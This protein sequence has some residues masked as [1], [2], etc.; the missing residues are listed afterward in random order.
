MKEVLLNRSGHTKYKL[1]DLEQLVIP[2]E[3]DPESNHK[4]KVGLVIQNG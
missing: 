2:S 1:N 3:A 4:K